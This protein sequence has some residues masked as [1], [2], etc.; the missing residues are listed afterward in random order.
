I[1]SLLFLAAALILSPIF[2]PPLYSALVYIS[3]AAGLGLL[4]ARLGISRH[5]RAS[6]YP[7]NPGCLILFLLLHGTVN[8]GTTSQ[9]VAI[10][11]WMAFALKAP[12]CIW[13]EEALAKHGSPQTDI[14]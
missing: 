13:R 7:I 5:W 6:G 1:E 10:I 3:C 9:L 12:F 14:T 8:E 11:F 4:A 2:R